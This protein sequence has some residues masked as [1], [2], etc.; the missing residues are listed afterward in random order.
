MPR[1]RA[2][3]PKTHWIGGWVGPSAGVDYIEKQKFMALLGLEPQPFSHPTCRELLYRLHY[4]SSKIPD[5]RVILVPHDTADI[6]FLVFLK[7]HYMRHVS[8][9]VAGFKCD[10]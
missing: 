2:Q 10:Q 3:L 5:S 9:K 6:I 1:K 4:H 8:T 7:R